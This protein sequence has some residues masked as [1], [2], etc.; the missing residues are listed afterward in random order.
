MSGGIAT[1][2]AG[3]VR[4]NRWTD[5]LVCAALTVAAFSTSRPAWG[6]DPA[7]D[8]LARGTRAYELGDLEQ[9]EM[10]L[11]KALTLLKAAS[12]KGQ[13]ALHLGLIRATRADEGGAR[14]WFRRALVEEPTLAL[15]SERAPPRIRTL[16]EDVRDSLRGTVVFVSPEPGVTILVDGGPA[17]ARQEL[18]IGKHHVR[19]RSADGLR[20]FEDRAFVVRAD[21]QARVLVKLSPR[22][23]RLTLRLRPSGASLYEGNDRIATAG[24]SALRIAAGPHTLRAAGQGLEPLERQVRLEP[25]GSIALDITLREA[26]RPWWQR[27]RTWAFVAAG[28]AG[29]AA[30][31]A[32]LAGR[33]ALASSDEIARLDRART[34]DARRYE[35]LREGVRTDS[36]AATVL[37]SVAGAA[38]L[39]CIPLFVLGRDNRTEAQWRVGPAGLGVS[40][41]RAF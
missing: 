24:Q 14:T 36:L 28:V 27:A 31:S 10:A 8:L 21:A 9:A 7:H 6:Q 38:A 3:R 39:S 2:I 33:S 35:V 26:L 15:D 37:W 29:A 13:A 41:G 12:H 4:S 16:F 11:T 18:P 5:F 20:Q 40:L 30:F 1:R 32:A 23:A 17:N 19:V 34:L 22:Q 25:D